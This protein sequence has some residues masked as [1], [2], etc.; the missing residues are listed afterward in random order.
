MDG[1]L[2]P[3]SAFMGGKLKVSGDMAV[4]M[5]LLRLI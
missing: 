2:D 3:T 5:R 4:A 1:K